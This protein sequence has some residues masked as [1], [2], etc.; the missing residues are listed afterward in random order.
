MTLKEELKGM[1][2]DT[3]V[4]FPVNWELTMPEDSLLP[5]E[6]MVISRYNRFM[7][8]D[9]LTLNEKK[10]MALMG[11]FLAKYSDE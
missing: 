9:D 7:D 11:L 2:K 4:E 3:L 1:Y 10:E 5:I 8:V 6:D